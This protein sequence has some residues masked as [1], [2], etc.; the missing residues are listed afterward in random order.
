MSGPQF[1]SIYNGFHLHKQATQRKPAA[2]MTV[3]Q[4]GQFALLSL[5]ALARNIACCVIWRS[6]FS[7]DGQAGKPRKLT[8]CATVGMGLGFFRP[9]R[10]IENAIISSLLAIAR[11]L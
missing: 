1:S 10:S 5:L 11:C 8:V 6:S 9:A 4:S 7:R 3:A 2:S